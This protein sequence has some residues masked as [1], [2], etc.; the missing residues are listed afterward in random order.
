MK[1]SKNWWWIVI[2]VVILIVIWF[3]V[4]FILTSEDTWIKN[5][6]G[7]YVKHGVPSDIPDYVK[8][9]QDAV[10]CALQLYQ[11]KKLEGMQ[12]SSQCLGTCGDYAVDIVHVPRNTE[13]DKQENQCS[14]FRE[15]KVRRF[16]E[17][18]NK[19]NIF[20]IV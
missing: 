1:K 12:F 8:Q 9:Q 16:I 5:E 3:G 14:D 20:R 7:E 10:T 17:L 11:Q 4:R 19:G 15:G 6:T 13:D 18:D 2:I